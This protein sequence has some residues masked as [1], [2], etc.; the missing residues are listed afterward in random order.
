[1]KEQ[2]IGCNSPACGGHQQ[3][4]FKWKVWYCQVTTQWLVMH[5]QRLHRRLHDEPCGQTHKPMITEQMREFIRQQDHCMIPPRLIHD[6]I[7]DNGDIFPPHL[8]YPTL[9]Q[10]HN[11]LKHMRRRNGTK[12]TLHA[13]KQTVFDMRYHADLD[14]TSPFVFG[15]AS[16]DGRVHVGDG[17]DEDPLV[18]GVTT[19]ALVSAALSFASPDRYAM[20][21][22]DA[23]FKLSD[24]GYPTIT[25]GFT[26]T[27]RNYQLGAVFIVSQRTV[28]EYQ[29]C[30]EA[31]VRICSEIQPASALYIDAVMG[32]AEDAQ[33][34]ALQRVKEFKSATF[35]MCFFHVLYNV[36]KRTRDLSNALRKTVMTDIMRLHVSESVDEFEWLREVIL[37][38]WNNT[39][40]LQQ[41]ST[42][43]QNHP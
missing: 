29:M 38:R 21:H 43:F 9:E 36:R 42:Y 32:D 2:R 3:C 39:S 19:R 37:D 35:V 25:C 10:I 23:T 16:S 4:T 33:Y 34:N 17:T 7:I 28:H 5:N 20:F 13:T 41:F 31:F 26:D 8:G 24:L 14:S 11:C 1:M 27:A 40:G 12:N 30:L 18:L 22:T 6:N 15:V